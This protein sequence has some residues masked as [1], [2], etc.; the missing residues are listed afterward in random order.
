MRG[1]RRWPQEA[2]AVGVKKHHEA[3]FRRIS[4]ANNEN[5]IEVE[6]GT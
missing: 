5:P 3:H 4:E 6:T 2:I 1:L